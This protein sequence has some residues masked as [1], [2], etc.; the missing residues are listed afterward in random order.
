[1]GIITRVQAWFRRDRSSVALRRRVYG[2]TIALSLAAWG[3]DHG[4]PHALDERTHQLCRRAIDQA[5][6]ALVSRSDPGVLEDALLAVRT[7]T[8]A[9]GEAREAVAPP[10]AVA[11]LL[12]APTLA[13]LAAEVVGYTPD[14]GALNLRVLHELVAD[15]GEAEH[16]LEQL[17][18]RLH[19]GGEHRACE[20][21]V[22]QLLSLDDDD[23]RH[24]L[25]AVA[26]N[27]GL[28][29]STTTGRP[30]SGR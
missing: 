23:L 28:R 11:H 21:T 14:R 29:S 12:D 15:A 18:W 1:M 25:E 3:R 8:A 9:A 13:P 17:V 24:V 16:V 4:D 22:E 26:L 27:R 2:D 30:R 5:G 10:R 20:V 6:E 7:A 19:D